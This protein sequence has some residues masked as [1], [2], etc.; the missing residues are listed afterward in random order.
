[1]RDLVQFDD[2]K[3][4]SALQEE[5]ER[6]LTRVVKLV[7]KLCDDV[8]VD[9]AGFEE[10]Q[11]REV[12]VSKS[13]GEAVELEKVV[14]KVIQ[15]KFSDV[16]SDI[17]YRL[18][19][20]QDVLKSATGEPH[21]V[22]TQHLNLPHHLLDGYTI[23][24]NSPSAGYVSW[25]DCHI[26][27]AGTDYTVSNSYTSQKYIYWR[28]TTPSVFQ[29]TNTKP[30]LGASDC[31]VIVNEN[32]T[33]VVQLVP[34]KLQSGAHLLDGTIGAA[35]LG[36][37]AVTSAKIA[38][39]AIFSAHISPSAIVSTHMQDGAVT[40]P[41]IGAGQVATSKLNLATHLLY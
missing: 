36:A 19:V 1:M 39:S 40:G 26:V 33:A 38:A 29:V 35:E 21:R 20:L 3:I 12:L 30:S 34:G 17:S 23:Y 22:T 28:Q 6:V 37:S 41:K 13:N 32:G 14:E 11:Q 16:L 2:R 15:E 25:S 5:R 27:Y 8:I 9:M 18:G 4:R 31:L 7:G 24:S 10:V